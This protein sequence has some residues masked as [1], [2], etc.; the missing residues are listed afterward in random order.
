MSDAGKHCAVNETAYIALD[1]H[2]HLYPGADPAVALS[3]GRDNLAAA[4]RVAG[5]HPQTFALIL[6]ETAADDAFTALASGKIAP[7]GWSICTFPDDPAALRARRL[8]DDAELLVFSGRQIVT[9]EKVEVLAL[10]TAERY[11]DGRPI[12]AV[13]DDLMNQGVPAVLPWGVGKWIGVRG[14]LIHKLID[15]ADP[16]APMLGDNAGR[17]RG[18]P[19]PTMF[20]KAASDDRPILP[21]SDP[22]PIPGS[23]TGIG[24]YGCLIQGKLDPLLPSVDLR[25]HICALQGLAEV[26]GRRRRLPA[27]IAE[28]IALRRRKPA[29]SNDGRKA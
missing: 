22:L 15:G 14:G 20:R 6:T 23:E 17:P 21:G 4:S 27:V 10:A 13:L 25:R 3:A 8:A 19:P 2:V 9:L 12:D 26:I 28:Q 7:D 18:W 24:R 11:Q 29:I 1:T 5:Y 16:V